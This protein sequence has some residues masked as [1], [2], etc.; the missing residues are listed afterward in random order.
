MN[1]VSMGHDYYAFISY[2]HSDE[3]IAKWLH[4]KLE[5]YRFPSRL[6]G[7]MTG[8]GRL[9][10]NL[11]PIFRDREELSA[12]SSLPEKV[13]RAL[14]ASHALLVICSPDA[15]ASAWV[16]RE[17]KEFRALHPERPILLALVDGSPETAFPPAISTGEAFAPY[18]PLASDLRPEGD[19]RR[20]GLLKLLAGL[21]DIPLGDLVQRDAQRK[22]RRVTTVTI[23]ALLAV[24]ILSTLTIMAVQARYEAER[25]RAS[26]EGL[27][28]FMLTDLRERLE[29]VGRLDILSAVNSRALD[30]YRRQD[31]DRLPVSSLERRAR[32]LLAMGEDDEQR[33]DFVRAL[34]QF[35][36]AARTTGRLLEQ[37]RDDPERIYAHAQSEFW[38]GL[39]A[40]RTQRVTAAQKAFERYEQLANQLV[41]Q[42]PAKPDWLMEA[43]Y[44][45]SNLGTLLLR[46]RGDAPA[47][48]KRFRASLI[49]FEKALAMKPEDDSVKWDIADSHGWIADAYRAQQRYAD[50][51]VERQRQADIL[52]DLIVKYP[53]NVQY[54]RGWLS[55]D[56]GTALVELDSGATIEAEKRLRETYRRATELAAMDRAN[57]NLK[58]Q[59]IATGLFL[60]KA[61]LRNAPSLPPPAR[62]ECSRLLADCT[63][64]TARGDAE[65]GQFCEL[66]TARLE[67]RKPSIQLADI[68]VKGQFSPRW[69]IDFSA[70]F[71]DDN[72]SGGK[73]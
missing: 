14:A 61:I 45:A 27:I 36:E 22:M 34:A 65:I 54:R 48:E 11:V 2:S 33:G 73:K 13:Q 62:R 40:W 39:I 50:A 32:I 7:K 5:T 21:V 42:E 66:L 38:F 37:D 41:E 4:R 23:V 26:A 49:R 35:E 55:N 57:D 68:A 51:L 1:R 25:Q 53:R 9:P 70:E 29:G 71:S 64:A 63:S 16:N 60:A 28:E 72:I 67:R 24:A 30:H 59:Q 52:K 58:K 43:G 12:G 17:I 69:G 46:D 6:V 8:F 56:M 19:G 44:A 10:R 31:L 18:E 3:A 47:A 15:A 20:L